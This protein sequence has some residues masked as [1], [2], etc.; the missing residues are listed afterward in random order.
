[1]R[2][3]LIEN[4]MNIMKEDDDNGMATTALEVHQIQHNFI[5]TNRFRQIAPEIRRNSTTSSVS[6]S[7][8]STMLINGKDNEAI[9]SNASNAFAHPRPIQVRPIQIKVEPIDP[10]EEQ[11]KEPSLIT[12]SPSS[13]PSIVTISSEAASVKRITPMVQINEIL[14]N[15]SFGEK[16]QKSCSKTPAPLSV[17]LGRRKEKADFTSKEGT[18]TLR[19][20]RKSSELRKSKRKVQKA[21]EAMSKRK[22]TKT[23]ELIIISNKKQNTDPPRKRGRPPKNAP[24]A[25]NSPQKPKAKAKKS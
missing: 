3:Y 20:A 4:G 7:G 17:K 8:T 1:M 23:K 2:Q 19:T 21:L 25:T 12:S 16:K 18:H 15:E 9:G 22:I 6:V 5:R 13:E 10:D 11:Q 14:N 24:S